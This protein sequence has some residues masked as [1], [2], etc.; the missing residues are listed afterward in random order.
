MGLLGKK[1]APAAAPTQG[2]QTPEQVKAHRETAPAQ[3]AAQTAAQTPEPLQAAR[4]PSPEPVRQASPAMSPEIA[5]AAAGGTLKELEDRL[6]FMQREMQEV[7][8]QAKASKSTQELLEAEVTGLRAML[9]DLEERK[10]DKRDVRSAV[11]SIATQ[12]GGSNDGPSLNEI[13]LGSYSVPV[14]HA[15]VQIP[16]MPRDLLSPKAGLHDATGRTPQVSPSRRP[17]VRSPGVASPSPTL[18]QPGSPGGY[19]SPIS[20][21][22]PAKS[23]GGGFGMMAPDVAG[24][25]SMM[26]ELELQKKN[27]SAEDILRLIHLERED[28]AVA[29]V[30]QARSLHALRVQDDGGRN[31]LTVAACHGMASLVGALLKS[32]HYEDAD[33]Q[34][35]DGWTAL[36]WAVL[37]GQVEICK[38][39]LASPKFKAANLADRVHSWTALHCAAK[40]GDTK[41]AKVLLDS[42]RFQEVNAR[43]KDLQTALHVSASFGKQAM[44]QLLLAHPRFTDKDA[45]DTLARTAFECASDKRIQ[46]MLRGPVWY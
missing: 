40:V 32:E 35:F 33:E 17:P 15:T 12:K 9:W 26:D 19:N 22:S 43:D 6:N 42:P 30:D 38:I 31:L 4:S 10:A 41:V 18:S 1:T 16:G 23:P 34:N 20:P 8:A 14:G 28:A 24:D 27:L 5:G 39:L 13:I 45:C 21:S 11:A 44:V 29:A 37:E 46:Q 25:S 3:T 2:P 36:H 7:L